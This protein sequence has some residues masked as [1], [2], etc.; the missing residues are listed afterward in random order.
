M[1]KYDD[2]LLEVFERRHVMCKT[3]ERSF[4][5]VD[6]VT[7]SHRMLWKKRANVQMKNYD[8]FFLEKSFCYKIDNS[9]VFDIVNVKPR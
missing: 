3:F 6:E 4:S 2:F 1:N 5:S 9:L 8:K 7:I